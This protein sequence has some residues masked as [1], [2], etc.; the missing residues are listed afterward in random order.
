MSFSC[1]RCVGDGED[2]N[3][4]YSA[5]TKHKCAFAYVR[6]DSSKKL[7]R[8]PRTLPHL[9]VKKERSDVYIEALRTTPDR[10]LG[11]SD[12]SLKSIAEV[13]D[14]VG[15]EIAFVT[16]ETASLCDAGVQQFTNLLPNDGDTPQERITAVV[17]RAVARHREMLSHLS[18]V[19]A[20]YDESTWVQHVFDNEI[21]S[22]CDL[23]ISMSRE[24]RQEM[25][26][27][28]MV[29]P[30]IDPLMP[31]QNL[32][33]AMLARQMNRAH[34]F[35]ES[36]AGHMGP[37]ARD[38]LFNYI[39]LGKWSLETSCR[40]LDCIV[41]PGSYLVYDDLVGT[42]G[43]PLGEGLGLP[44]RYCRRLPSR[45]HESRTSL[46]ASVDVLRN[47][48]CAAMRTYRAEGRHSKGDECF[49]GMGHA[50][51]RALQAT[52]QSMD[53]VSGAT[54]HRADAAVTALSLAMESTGLCQV[55][56]HSIGH[57]ATRMK[58]DVQENLLDK[59]EA[60]RDDIEDVER[61][62]LLG[63]WRS[64]GVRGPAAPSL[65]P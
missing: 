35:I 53:D 49:L 25:G 44:C 20:H 58:A 9:C 3:D 55:K 6:M 64:R 43:K 45:V 8:P 27:H 15:G 18:P 19:Q 21:D 47:G 54:D 29:D 24:E 2:S 12:T 22:A 36:S 40:Y 28:R 41:D 34:A 23:F 37:D 17:N 31:A 14:E 16:F 65:D 5:H 57:F 62:R 38:K 1:T 11:Q 13:A 51:V 10:E 48:I 7:S 32:G 39:N 30:G 33:V 26:L 4:P 63:E 61:A 46:I 56:M 60:L 50:F 59:S 52:R 42:D